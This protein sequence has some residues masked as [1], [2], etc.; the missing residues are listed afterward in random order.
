MLKETN[1]FKKTK[2]SEKTQVLMAN[3]NVTDMAFQKDRSRTYLLSRSHT[4]GWTGQLAADPTRALPVWTQRG[5]ILE[6][7]SPSRLAAAF[8]LHFHL[9]VIKLN[10]QKATQASG[11]PIPST[12]R[13]LG[14]FKFRSVRKTEGFKASVTII[15]L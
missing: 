5:L 2:K 13:M 6:V 3:L 7:S 14:Q 9:S 8:W 1:R 4:W 11:S 10:Q 15:I 12:R